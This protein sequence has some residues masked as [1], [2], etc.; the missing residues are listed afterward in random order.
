[1][2]A[3]FGSDLTIA[4]STQSVNGSCSE[5]DFAAK[6]NSELYGLQSTEMPVTCGL[7]LCEELVV[8]MTR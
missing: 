6:S 1:M 4:E 2:P 8:M 7:M 3:V 5:F